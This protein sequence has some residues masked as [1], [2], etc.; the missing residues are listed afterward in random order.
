MIR[1]AAARGHAI[2]LTMATMLTMTASDDPN[3]SNF[4]P[5]SQH[6]ARALASMVVASLPF[7][8]LP[9][10]VLQG[11]DGADGM[12]SS[13]DL[14]QTAVMNSVMN[15]Q[16][17]LRPGGKDAAELARSKQA[18]LERLQRDMAALYVEADGQASQ[19]SANSPDDRAWVQRAY[20]IFCAAFRS[21]LLDHYAISSRDLR[22]YP[23]DAVAADSVLVQQGTSHW[24][25]S[26]LLAGDAGAAG[27]ENEAAATPARAASP[28]WLRKGCSGARFSSYKQMVRAYAL[29]LATL[30]D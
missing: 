4:A 10:V 18:T 2:M 12:A 22:F 17:G 3:S 19:N 16:L 23:A 24:R 13:F 15:S 25:A 5:R 27:E 26:R 1:S 8:P 28:P 9:V 7:P 29:D 11:E 30:S 6:E 21:F 14:L 20:D